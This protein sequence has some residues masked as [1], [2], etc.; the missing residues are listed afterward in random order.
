MPSAD[1]SPSAGR[2]RVVKVGISA[3][4][5]VLSTVIDAANRDYQLSIPS[6]GVADPDTEVHNF[7]LHRVF[8][9]RVHVID[10]TEPRPLPG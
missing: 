1:R 2:V 10:T 9:S 7:L 8:P 5:A 6:D 4:G 3:I